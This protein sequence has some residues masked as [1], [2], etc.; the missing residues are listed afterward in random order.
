MFDV[1]KVCD[2]AARWITAWFEEHGKGC[3]AVVGISGGKDSAVVAALCVKALGADRVF[4]VLMPNGIQPDIDAAEL[5]CAHLGIKS[6]TVNIKNAVEGVLGELN[7]SL[8]EISEATRINVQPRIRM[9]VVY[10]VAQ[11][12]NGRVANTCNLSE[13]FVGY[14]TRYGD[15]AGDFSPL[16]NLTVTEVKAI[17]NALGLP[18]QIVNKLPIDGL[19]GKSDEENLG[20]SYDMLDTYIRTGVCEDKKIKERIDTLNRLNKFKLELMQS[21]PYNS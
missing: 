14:A 19:C 13:D 15:S 11:S 4:G 3:T 2:D 20:F 7:G 21:F 16:Q 10:A 1:K 5:V 17:G 8:P 6:I 18:K 9:A 12:V